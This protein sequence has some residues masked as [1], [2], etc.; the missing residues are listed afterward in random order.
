L[1]GRPPEEIGKA[2]IELQ[3]RAIAELSALPTPRGDTR[4]IGAV[5]LHLRRVQA[6]MRL[7]LEA[8]GEDALPAVAGIAVE[9]DAVARAA[10]RYG[11]FQGCGAYHEHPEV[12]RVLHDQRRLRATRA[13]RPPAVPE[14]RRLASALVP[15]GSSVLRRQDCAGGDPSAPSCVTIELNPHAGHAADRGAE[16]ARLAARAGWTRL[17][18]TS[19]SPGAPSDRASSGPLAFHR[20]GYDATVWLARADCAPRLGDGPNPSASSPGCVDTIMVTVSP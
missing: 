7:L 3:G 8:K 9:M 17:K 19:T 1:K 4:E 11:L 13:P 16:I 20:D 18:P 12:Q 10:K 2:A 14:I 6:A 5:L 15:P